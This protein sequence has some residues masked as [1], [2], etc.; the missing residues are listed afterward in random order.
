MLAVVA[1]GSLR[2]FASVHGQNSLGVEDL[3]LSVMEHEGQRDSPLFQLKNTPHIYTHHVLLN[4][5]S[6]HPP[7]LPPLPDTVPAGFMQNLQIHDDLFRAGPITF[8]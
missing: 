3:P 7:L 8:K 6:V 5:F 4:P 2:T 1:L